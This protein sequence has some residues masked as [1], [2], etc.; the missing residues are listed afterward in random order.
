MTKYVGFPQ[1]LDRKRYLYC[2]KTVLTPQ[3]ILRTSLKILR[4]TLL[5]N[6]IKFQMINEAQNEIIF[7]KQIGCAIAICDTMVSHVKKVIPKNPVILINF[8][9]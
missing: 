3:K 7:V 8:S 2:I 6:C 1:F 9:I 5:T 4:C